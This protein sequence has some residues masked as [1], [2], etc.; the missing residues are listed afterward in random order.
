[1][2]KKNPDRDFC[3][4]PPVRRRLSRFNTLTGLYNLET[5]Q[6][7]QKERKKKK[8]LGG[9]APAWNFAVC[10]GEKKKKKKKKKWS[11]G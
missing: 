7:K 4:P 8:R 1:M 5:K 2:S 11:L 9:L 6:I 3:H 10:Y